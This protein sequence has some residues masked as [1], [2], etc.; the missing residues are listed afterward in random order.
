MYAHMNT[1][2]SKQVNVIQ[3]QPYYLRHKD[4]FTSNLKIAWSRSLQ[5]YLSLARLTSNDVMFF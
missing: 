1:I 4:D 3:I 5:H 2:I